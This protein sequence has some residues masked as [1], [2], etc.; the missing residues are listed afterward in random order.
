MEEIKNVLNEE[1]QQ[2]PQVM[3]EPGKQNFSP[4]S[5]KIL[6][7]TAFWLRIMAIAHYVVAGLTVVM[8]LGNIINRSSIMPDMSGL[9][10]FDLLMQL[11]SSF[12]AG[13]LGWYLQTISKGYRKFSL[14]PC[15]INSLEVAFSNQRHFWR[16]LGVL[17]LIL[18]SGFAISMLLSI[19]AKLG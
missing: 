14:D 9:S 3:E 4:E 18:L 12:L 15:D 19:L 7:K 6:S 2:Q 10:T 5:L 1:A 11:A 13:L 16:L 17:A 8:L